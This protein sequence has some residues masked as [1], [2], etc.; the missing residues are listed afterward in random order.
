MSYLHCEMKPIWHNAEKHHTSSETQRKEQLH[1]RE[2]HVYVLWADLIK[3]YSPSNPV[4]YKLEAFLNV[5]KP[6]KR[7]RPTK[8]VNDFEKKKDTCV[9]FFCNYYYYFMSGT[10][11]LPQALIRSNMSCQIRQ[12]IN[13]GRDQSSPL[14][15][16]EMEAGHFL[17]TS[18]TFSSACNRKQNKTAFKGVAGAQIVYE[19]FQGW[20]LHAARKWSIS[21]TTHW[22]ED[23]LRCWYF[24]LKFC[25]SACEVIHQQPLFFC[26]FVLLFCFIFWSHI[27]QI[28]S[29]V[30]LFRLWKKICFGQKPFSCCMLPCFSCF[31][32]KI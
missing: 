10:R 12:L 5:F 21:A 15:D 19:G 20:C 14:T 11:F 24:C 23:R 4:L 27:N 26:I 29:A 25:I 7:N 32:A 30:A 28:Q 31:L 18:L 1:C 3:L 6:Y 2:W 17:S 8:E 16:G 13:Q 22:E 9:C